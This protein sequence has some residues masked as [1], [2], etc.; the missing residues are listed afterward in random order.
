MKRIFASVLLLSSCGVLLQTS[1]QAATPEPRHGATEFPI[2]RQL[3]CFNDGGFYWP[4]DGS[5]IP[6]AG[7]RAAY[8]KGFDGAKPGPGNEPANPV[9]QGTYPFIQ[10]AEVAVLIPDYTNPAAVKAAIPDGTLCSAGQH[11]QTWDERLKVWNDKSGLDEPGDWARTAVTKDANNKLHVKFKISAVHNPSYWEFYITKPGFDI[12][13]DKLTWSNTVLLEK[14]PN[15]PPTG[16][17]YEMDV[18]LKDNVGDRT[19]YV[20]WQ[21]EDSKGEGFY[22]CSD[23][24]I[25][26]A[27]GHK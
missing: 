6:N 23:V 7:C 26:P 8:R 24:T 1:A 25:A 22:N 4:E 16:N 17:Y 11:G 21:R 14:I 5:G 19:L 9:G 2:A 27:K 3:K 15:V 10:W 20:R 12:K 18:D 13:K